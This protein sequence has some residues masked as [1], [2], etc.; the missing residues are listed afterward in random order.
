MG[1]LRTE[2]A[3]L[4]DNTKFGDPLYLVKQHGRGRVA[5]LTT[6][7]GETWTDWPAMP[8]GNV[9]FGPMMKELATYLSGG[10]A[11]ENRSVGE[12][13]ALKL[14][15][16]KYRNS[17]SHAFQSHDPNRE[18]KAG[19]ADAAPITDLGSLTLE[20]EGASLNVKIAETIKPGAHLLTLSQLRS[21]AADAV[22]APDYRAFAVNIDSAREG[23]LRRVTTD[24]LAQYA[25]QVP[26]HSPAQTDWLEGLKNKS[27]DLSEFA[28]LFLVLLLILIAEQA[29]AVK[30][31]YHAAAQDTALLAPSAA[32]VMQARAAAPNLTAE[33]ATLNA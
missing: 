23:D 4:R 30:L 27:K 24:D 25:P 21:G 18:A 1:D 8:P 14:D 22:D 28:V 33:P 16:A 29:L 31:S 19:G 15:A 6:T 32:A 13:I 11:E 2:I 3:R 20:G 10:G 5:V 7:A 12:P 17:A 26:V 9:S